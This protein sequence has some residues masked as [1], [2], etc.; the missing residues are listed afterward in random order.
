MLTSVTN[1]TNAELR[2]NQSICFLS[3]S[4]ISSKMYYEN[5]YWGT[6][7]GNSIS[8]QI[9][10]NPE[11]WPE[12]W[13]E[14]DLIKRPDFNQQLPNSSTDQLKTMFGLRDAKNQSGCKHSTLCIYSYSL[15]LDTTEWETNLLDPVIRKVD[16]SGSRSVAINWSH[17]SAKIRFWP[18]HTHH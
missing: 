2:L 6:L 1:I 13:L 5:I 14:L 10:L 9:W 16:G 15:N 8:S 3:S 18:L 12:F 17:S 7:S 11:I 4:L